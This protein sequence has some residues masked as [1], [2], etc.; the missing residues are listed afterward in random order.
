[1]QSAARI[2]HGSLGS[3]IVYGPICHG[4]FVERRDTTARSDLTYFDSTVAGAELIWI[5]ILDS[6]GGVD[7]ESGGDTEGTFYRGNARW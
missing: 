5:P 2:G 4:I 7:D 3:M 6:A 1:L